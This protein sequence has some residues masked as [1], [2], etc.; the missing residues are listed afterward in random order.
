MGEWDYPFEHD[1]QK[2]GVDNVIAYICTF[3]CHEIFHIDGA[4]FDK[5][6][7]LAEFPQL[8][9]YE[10]FSLQTVD[11]LLSFQLYKSVYI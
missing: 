2:C 8:C 1:I 10:R 11:I 5:T 9:R 6:G 7:T 4:L 3:L